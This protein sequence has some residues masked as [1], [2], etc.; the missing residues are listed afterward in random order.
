MAKT[1]EKSF[2]PKKPVRGG[3]EEKLVRRGVSDRLYLIV[4]VVI[5][6]IA[7]GAYGGLLYY[8]N[9]LENR[10]EEMSVTLNEATTELTSSTPSISELEAIGKSTEAVEELLS[11]HLS[12][13][14]LFSIIADS[15]ARNIQYTNFSY[16]FAPGG[17]SSGGGEGQSSGGGG[18]PVTIVMSG[19]APNFG[20][21]QA[22]AS[23]YA[24]EGRIDSASFSSLGFRDEDGVTFEVTLGMDQKEIAYAGQFAE[25]R[26]EARSGDSSDVSEDADS[27]AS[28]QGNGSPFTDNGDAEGSVSI[29]GEDTEPIDDTPTPLPNFLL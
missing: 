6:L 4:G 27:E 20:A 14:L 22:Q 13:S 15:T 8:K 28:D 11:G 2:I 17:T 16:S 10:I 24:E 23:R 9:V 12:P 21:I 7:G 1:L 5:F 29:E 18:A 3:P 26:E 25:T 19:L